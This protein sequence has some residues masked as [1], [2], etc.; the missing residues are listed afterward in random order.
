MTQHIF[1]QRCVR[2][3]ELI[4]GNYLFH[5]FW[6]FRFLIFIIVKVKF[7]HFSFKLLF[8]SHRFT[9]L[10]ITVSKHLITLCRDCVHGVIHFDFF[11]AKKVAYFFGNHHKRL[12]IFNFLGDTFKKGEPFLAVFVLGS[13]H[14]LPDLVSSYNEP[15]TDCFCGGQTDFKIRFLFV[16][17]SVY[18]FHPGHKLIH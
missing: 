1:F 10:D 12:K 16:S 17:L 18:S 9:E 11:S 2:L 8:H 14:V 4:F 7:T 13:E 3:F 15:H 5:F 6:I